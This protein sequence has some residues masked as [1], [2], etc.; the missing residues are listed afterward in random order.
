MVKRL[1]NYLPF[2]TLLVLPLLFY[3]GAAASGW[4]S[5]SDVHAL[6]EFASSLLAITAGIMVLLHFLATGRRFFLAV[7]IGFVLIGAEELFHALFSFE[8][9]WPEL[10]WTVKSPVSTTWVAGNFALALSLLIALAV[11][12]REVAVASRRRRAVVSSVVAFAA[13]MLLS[14]LA[15]VSPI[16]ASFVQLGSTSKRLIELSLGLLFLVAFLLYANLYDKRQSRSPLLWS[17]VAFS[18]LRV[19]VHLLVFDARAFYD[20]RWDTAHLVVLLSYFFP[21][22]G[23][24][25]ETIALHRSA[26]A[27]L[28]ELGK[29]VAERKRLEASLQEA[30]TMAEHYLSVA[31]E[32]ILRLDAQGTITLL[33]DSGHRLL[34]YAPGELIGKNWFD[35]C[36]PQDVWTEV[37]GVFAKLMSGYGADVL[38][39]E[40]SAIT[41]NGTR[42]TLLWHNSVLR[43]QDSRIV[44]TLSSAE[45]ITER[46]STQRAL[47]KSEQELQF[48][49]EINQVGVWDLDL[50]DHTAYRTLAHDRIFGYQTLLPQWT[51]EMFLEHVVLEDRAEVDRK[52]QEATSKKTDW[53]FEC[54]IRRIDGE[55]RW[56]LAAGRHFGDE[57]GEASHMVGVV[58]DI[59]ERKHTEAQLRQSQ[60]MEAIGT[61]AGGVAHDFNNLLTGILGN[62]TLMR[63]SLHTADPLLDNLNA[64]EA[65]VRQ[66]ASLTRGLLTFSHSAVVL[67]EPG[68][69][70][71]AL[72]AAL[73][74]LQ[75]SLPATIEIVRD[76][77]QA[78]WSVLVDQS[79]IT[80]V[81]L[82][83]A[84]NARDAMNG[85]GTLTIRATNEVVGEEYVQNHSH[86]RIGEFVHLSI[87]DTGPGIP[88]E[89]R[90]H[91]FEPFYTTKPVGSGTGLGLSVVFGAV[92]QA[93]GWITAE[94]TEGMGATFDIYLPR[95]PDEPTESVGHRPISVGVV[96]GTVL[97]VEDEPVVRVV[98]QTLLSRSGYTVLTAADG[99]SALN[100]LRDHPA[101]IGL[102]LLDMTMPGMT[103]DEIVLAIQA[104]DPTVPI[105]LTSGY[106][107][108]QTVKHL[109]DEGRVH[110][111][112]GKPYELQQLLEKVQELLRRS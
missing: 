102:I 68:K 73:A 70:A 96:S 67:S 88:P 72:D 58:Q 77:D 85:R 63:G 64:A 33:N 53:S 84:A 52:F 23:V 3:P 79:Q 65:A 14:W 104:L 105:L 5:S 92:E 43:D 110:G 39:Y 80:Q 108:D 42:L 94:S 40:A 95:C 4:R 61:L 57:S 75:Q 106:T 100:A 98:A 93:G 44:G 97:V 89:I 28:I 20:A 56:I 101:G 13:A 18:V 45:D 2:V 66:A 1:V 74:L 32:V 34:G 24:W 31:A 10:T 71:S 59:T 78:G 37:R 55:I 109:L 29:E 82:N 111:F 11:G 86:A 30:K 25:S 48:C 12:D 49:L 38:T 8:R 99:P 16:P 35:T 91:M 50:V 47:R 22:F 7:S 103:T 62:I 54:R 21:I 6:L 69:I 112:L 81:L 41:R 60:K 76:Y 26:H 17:I 36:L 46:K 27:Q 19:V 9:I 90:E 15:F 87:T 51:Y 107:S 83:L